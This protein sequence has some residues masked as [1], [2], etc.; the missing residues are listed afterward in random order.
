MS[1]TFSGNTASGGANAGGSIFNA[2]SGQLTVSNSTFINNTADNQGG[3]IHNEDT[4]I[5]SNSTLFGNSAP[6]GGGIS[7]L[8]SGTATL[9]NTIVGGSTSGGNCAGV[10]AV[11]STNNM[12]TDNTCGSSFAQVTAAQLN[13]GALT[14]SPAYLP[15][16]PGSVAIDAGDNVSCTLADQRGVP[17][18]QDGDD[19]D[20][21]AVC[22]IGAYEATFADLRASKVNNVGGVA[23]LSV[24]FTWT[25]TI[26]NTGVE[27]AAFAAGQVIFRDHLPAGASYGTPVA[28]NP[29]NV[30]NAS[31][32][33]CSIASNVLTC[34]AGS[35]TVTL[36]AATGKFEVAFSATPTA[37]G[38][39]VN[40]T[41]GPCRADPD[42]GIAESEESNNDC[43]NTVTVTARVHL[44]LVLK[45]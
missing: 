16:N 25:A 3:G 13:F 2:S 18:P 10:I 6:S 24:P 29:V 36:G 5:V 14:G 44:P 12:A 45:Q 43:A 21:V 27:P 28:Q 9:R 22:D 40:P 39:L 42:G 35:A 15:L 1:S 23:V 34:T 19:A 7:T 32:I 38:S 31:N 26:S 4:L 11:G 41:G 37:T 8:A 30:T 17:R 20:S 33:A